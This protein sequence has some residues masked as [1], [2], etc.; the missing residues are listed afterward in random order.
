[1]GVVKMLFIRV[2]QSLVKMME[3]VVTVYVH[4]YLGFLV[5]SVKLLF[6]WILIPVALLYLILA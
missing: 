2:I 3:L 1:V 5:I 4:V 6:N